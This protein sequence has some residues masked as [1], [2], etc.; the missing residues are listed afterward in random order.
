VFLIPAIGLYT[1]GFGAMSIASSFFDKSGYFA[2]WC[3]RTWS[4][5]ILRTTGV[6]VDVSGLEQLDPKGTYVFVANHQ[7]I[8]DIP[9]LFGSLPHQLR[10]IAKESLGNFPVIGWHLRRTGHMLVDRSRPDRAKIFGWASRL[11]SNGLSLILFPEG[12]RSR[13]GHVAKFKGGSFFL[14]LEA[15]LPVVP[16]SIVG[17]RHVMLKGRLAAYPGRVRL[18]V[19]P[20]IDTRGMDGADA[21]AFA[22]RVR[23]II[24]PLAES[25]V[26]RHPPDVRG[27]D[28]APPPPKAAARL[29]EAKR[30]GGRSV[31]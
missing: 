31:P 8:Y 28:L 16:L 14:A 6:H 29:A 26:D 30:E 10:I 22:E 13:D 1:V 3:A 12:T 21:R 5:W 20:P 18:V 15:G 2:H 17:S 25:D 23:Q 9:I 24:A 4:R 19:H 27:A 7:S 11:T